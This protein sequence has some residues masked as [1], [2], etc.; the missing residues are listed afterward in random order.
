MAIYDFANLDDF[1]TA[2]EDRMLAVVQ[3]SIERVCEIAQTPIQQ[4]GRMPVDTS[5]LRNSFQS[6]LN[7]STSLTGP[8]SYVLVIGQLEIG[9]TANFGWTAAHAARQNYGFVGED[10]LG[11]SY[12]QSGKHFLENAVGQF[13]RVVAE[14]TEKLKAILG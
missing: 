6:S 14:E 9:D 7:G 13:R 3:T 2:T 12:N 11:R 10:K 5:A 1:V 8:E 4:G